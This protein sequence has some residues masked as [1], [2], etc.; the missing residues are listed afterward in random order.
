MKRE[1]IVSG[2]IIIFLLAVPLE[3]FAKEA[4]ADGFCRSSLSPKIGIKGREI[5]LAFETGSR[6]PGAGYVLIPEDART[7]SGER[8]AGFIRKHEYFS[9]A[10]YHEENPSYP[11]GCGTFSSL[12]S[13][14]MAAEGM[15]VYVF[16][17]RMR[18]HYYMSAAVDFGFGAEEAIIDYTSDQITGE[19][20]A[21]LIGTRANLKKRFPGQYDL[22]WAED[23]RPIYPGG[24]LVDN[25]YLEYIMIWELIEDLKAAMAESRS[26]F[27]LPEMLVPPSPII[28]NKSEL[29][30]PRYI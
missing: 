10:Y 6:H 16:W 20:S 8:L 30:I 29:L 28:I 15:D 11:T 9:K 17:S 24:I 27:T 21:P 23:S 7:I 1:R 18:D 12:I 13:E 5:K 3:G 26:T 4:E 19:K 25:F 22:Y 2:L 14:A